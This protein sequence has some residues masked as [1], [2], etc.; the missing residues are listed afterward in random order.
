M[1]DMSNGAQPITVSWLRHWVG[2]LVMLKVEPTFKL[3]RTFRGPYRVHDFTPTC[4]LSI[5]PINSP[6]E[7]T[8]FVSLQRLSCCHETMLDNAKPWLEH[9]K[10]RKRRQRPGPSTTGTNEGSHRSKDNIDVNVQLESVT[11]SGQVV[12]KPIRYRGSSS[13]PDGSAPHQGGSCKE[14]DP[15]RRYVSKRA[16]TECE[17][18]D[19]C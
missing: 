13:C 6:N 3:D 17:H 11:R 16:G 9:G 12:R 14:H 8:I 15:Q 19:W 4:A 2:D 5:Q 18:A 10:V 7:E 1:P